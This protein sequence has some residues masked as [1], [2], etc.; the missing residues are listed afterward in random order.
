MVREQV[1]DWL[2]QKLGYCQEIYDYVNKFIAH[3]ATPESRAVIGADEI[4]ITLGKLYEGHKVICK[5]S[6]FIGLTL[7]NHRFGNFLISCAFD[8][9]EHF[10]KPW[11]NTET[12]KKLHEFWNEYDRETRKW[13]RC[14]WQGEFNH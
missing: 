13:N 1:F 12:V 7:L 3:A 11:A 14:D 4:K 8:Q 9:F 10:E 5:T 2:E 6:Q